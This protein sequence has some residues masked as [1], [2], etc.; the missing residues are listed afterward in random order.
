[1][2]ASSLQVSGQRGQQHV[3][4][5]HQ[6]TDHRLRYAHPR[7]QGDLGQVSRLANLRKALRVDPIGLGHLRPRDSISEAPRG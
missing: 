4:L 1:M 7:G 2:V 6:S 5:A 3:V